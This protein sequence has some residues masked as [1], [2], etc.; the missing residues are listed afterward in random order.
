MRIAQLDL[1]AFGHFTDRRIAFVA[2]TDFH[3]AYGPNEAGKTTISRALKAALF[4][5]LERTTDNY[6]H[7]NPNM[8][9]GVVLGQKPVGLFKFLACLF[10]DFAPPTG[11]G[12]CCHIFK[13][14]AFV[15]SSRHLG[16]PCVQRLLGLFGIGRRWS[17][18]A[19]ATVRVGL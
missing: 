2:G 15:F 6:L 13:G 10:A 17:S 18:C 19:L 11:V 9:V 5:V 14:A 3:I 7:A 4:G 12:L 16:S 1:K 8:R